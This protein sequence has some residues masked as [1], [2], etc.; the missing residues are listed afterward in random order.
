MYN[1]AESGL[2][3]GWEIVEGAVM[4]SNISEKLQSPP[5]G[6]RALNDWDEDAINGGITGLRITNIYIVRHCR[7]AGRVGKGITRDAQ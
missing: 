1:G 4:T 2:Q 5:F 7:V 6:G 3:W